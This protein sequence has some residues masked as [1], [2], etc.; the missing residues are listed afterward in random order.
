MWFCLRWT[1]Y[2]ADT[3][4]EK[5]YIKTVPANMHPWKLNSIDEETGA[6]QA[7]VNAW[8][9]IIKDASKVPFIEDNDATPSTA[10]CIINLD[11][12]F[13]FSGGAAITYHSIDD[14]NNTDQNYTFVY[15]NSMYNQNSITGDKE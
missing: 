11:N 3:E 1:H 15:H 2:F 7:A 10:V 4:D 13:Y 5:I 6:A 8:N 14:D 12:N 9:S